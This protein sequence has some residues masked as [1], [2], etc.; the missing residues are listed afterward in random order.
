MQP[1]VDSLQSLLPPARYELRRFKSGPCFF[2]RTDD[3][4]VVVQLV[5]APASEGLQHAQRLVHPNVQQILELFPTPAGL[6]VVR[7]FLPAH[8]LSTLIRKRR[9]QGGYQV[10][11]FH[12]I[13]AQCCAGLAAIH[14]AGLVH[15][16]LSPETIRV[17]ESRAALLD[18]ELPDSGPRL[19]LP[20]AP[21]PAHGGRAYL[22]PVRLRGGGRSPED[23][24]YALG[25]TLLQMWTCRIPEVY[26]G[27]LTRPLRDQIQLDAF[28][29]LTPR[30]L[31]HLH[32]MLQ[33]DPKKRPQAQDLRFAASPPAEAAEPP[34][35][36]AAPLDDEASLANLSYAEWSEPP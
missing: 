2:R 29:A 25:L 5:D 18:F 31:Q 16:N 7:A 1:D 11:E 33:A 15:G 20:D 10:G 12:R 23:D 3:T 21:R 26:R 36:P 19:S 28:A 17:D 30:D 34:E 35:E 32:R 9:A 14:A 8:D 24:V 6:I 27:P 13:A 22:S 4:P